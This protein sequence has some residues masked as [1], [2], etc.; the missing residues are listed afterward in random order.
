MEFF[1]E[2]FDRGKWSG[3]STFKTKLRKGRSFKAI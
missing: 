3:G 1:F 2:T